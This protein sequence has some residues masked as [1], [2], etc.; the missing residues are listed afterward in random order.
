MAKT[1]NTPKTSAGKSAAKLSKKVI[2]GAHGKVLKIRT[3]VHFYKPKTLQLARAP[4]YA[5]K[6]VP[7]RNKLDKYRIIKSPLTTESAMKKIEDNNT[8]VFLVDLL[9]NKRQIKDAVK[10]LYDIKVAKVNTLIRP[11]GQ[12]KAYVRLTAD[13]DALDVAN[14]IGV[15]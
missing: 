9:A 8:L 2:K 1:T 12:K 7:S 6:A 11:D 3:K 15:I 13:Y 14:R 5:R 4:L 10:Q